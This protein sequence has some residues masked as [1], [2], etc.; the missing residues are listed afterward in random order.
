MKTLFRLTLLALALLSSAESAFAGCGLFR[1]GGC[2]DPCTAGA[3]AGV[4]FHRGSC[5]GCASMGGVVSDHRQAAYG[6]AAYATGGSC[7]NYMPSSYVQ[8]GYVQSSV[9]A[10][11]VQY[12]PA[13]PTINYSQPI[14]AATIQ[15]AD[16]MDCGPVAS[17]QVVMQTEYVTETRQVPVTEYTD[18]TRYR[19]RKVSRQ[20][21]VEVQDYRTK[22]V[23]VPTTE[24]KTVEYSVLVPHQTEKTVDV[25][26]SV[27]VW[28]EV[29][30]TYTVKVPNVTEVSEEYTV[31]VP[32]LKDE[33]F[34]Y[35]VHVPQTQTQQRTHR[36]V[37]AVPVTKTRTI[38]V[39][40]PVTRSQT[41]TRDQGH[42][43]MRVEEVGCSAGN[44][45]PASTQAISIGGCGTGTTYVNSGCGA[46]ATYSYSGCGQAVSSSCGGCGRAAKSCGCGRAAKSCGCGTT[47]CGCN[48]G[49]NNATVASSGYGCGGIAGVVS[50]PAAQ[51]VTRRVWVPNVVTE[52][53]PVIENVTEQ[54]VLNYTSFEQQT[55]D[56]PVECTTVVYVSEQ[57]T[58]TRKVVDY[59]NETRTRTRKVVQYNEEPRTRTRKE[60]SYKQETKTQT[61]PQVSYTTEKRTK[62][63]SFTVNVPQ[64]QV[65]PVTTTRYD[66]VQEE[67]SEPYTVRVP[68]VTYREQQCQVARMVPKL[69]PVTINPC[70]SNVSQGSVS[71]G[72]TMGCGST[73]GGCNSC[74]GTPTL[75][76]A[77]S[78]PCR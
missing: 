53:V 55:T 43:E 50:A 34:T 69:V 5:G 49:C 76:P 16:L 68:V 52:E 74:Y 20:V 19:T 11:S 9:Q 62:E 25:I 77:Q 46:Q 31:R 72:N 1:R 14:N 63:V 24:T 78:C 66:T 12:A 2:S 65:E 18:E 27:P 39:S 29:T 36:V 44:A 7:T 8:Q 22:T 38:Q 61:I 15:R 42:W 60:L 21:P 73:G 54:Q 41:V 4:A 64:T 45:A 3:C 26:E 13:A 28:N 58:G 56:V 57:R 40:R 37:N 59:V 67:V 6:H 30:E 10:S 48:S 33:S 70:Q 17:Y 71:Y 47:S 32:Q 75:A 35:T 51:T 23:M